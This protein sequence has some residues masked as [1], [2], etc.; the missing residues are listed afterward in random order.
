[1]DSGYLAQEDF[2]DNVEEAWDDELPIWATIASNETGVGF[3]TNESTYSK[4]TVHPR[5]QH[6]TFGFA[7][8]NEIQ[9]RTPNQIQGG[10]DPIEM[11]YEATPLGERTTQLYL[12]PLSAS[13]MR[14]GLR[15]AV[16][17]SVRQE[18]ELSDF[19]FLHMCV[20]T[21]DFT[22]LWAKSSDLE[23]NSSLWLKANMVEDELLLDS[24]YIEAK[25]GDVKSAWLVEQWIDEQS[26]R[27]I[28]NELD[29]SPGDVHHRVDLI[30]WLM[31]GARHILLADDV[32]SQEHLTIVAEIGKVLDHLSQRIK[33]GCRSDLLQL[34]N[35][36]KVGRQRARQLA[37]LGI[38]TPHDVLKM[39][40]QQEQIILSK[41]G[42]GPLLLKNI[43][44][45]IDKLN[46]SKN[47]PQQENVR[48]DDVPLD[49]ETEP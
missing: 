5:T 39:T 29:V 38:R 27:D 7:K 16:R 35:I 18:G 46:T 43:L 21:P 34:V 25:L 19:S 47:N 13:M 44:E 4:V 20:T 23:P 22:S 11:E 15:R 40:K 36:R 28:E 8:A 14:T 6:V 9:R 32:F 41:R 2:D 30:G 12:D 17:R 45:E 42:W 31:A 1:V 48:F 3:K 10:I 37:E 49:G 26:L 33:H 24:G